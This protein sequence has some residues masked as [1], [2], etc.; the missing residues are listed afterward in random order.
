V[1]VN[2]LWHRFNYLGVALIGWAAFILLQMTQTVVGFWM[3]AV[4]GIVL[5]LAAI[6]TSVVRIARTA[7]E[8]IVYHGIAW[9]LAVA[10]GF[11]SYIFISA[12]LEGV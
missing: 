10:L 11:L 9:T 6:F 1:P 8:D 3:G 12:V 4:A 7:K 5:A 2:K